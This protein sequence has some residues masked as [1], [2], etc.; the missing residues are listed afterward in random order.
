MNR[1]NSNFESTINEDN[2]EVSDE[3]NN[4]NEEP[5]TKKEKRSKSFY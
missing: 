5:I 3:N 4:L 1:I 2:L